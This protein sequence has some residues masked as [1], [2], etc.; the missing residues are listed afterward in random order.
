V[1]ACRARTSH[2]PYLGP[3]P[4]IGQTLVIPDDAPVE[5]AAK[6]RVKVKKILWHYNAETPG[7]RRTRVAPVCIQGAIS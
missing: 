3:I 5:D 6:G 1:T 2:H 7:M 4:E